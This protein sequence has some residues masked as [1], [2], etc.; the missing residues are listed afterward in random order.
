MSTRR[1]YGD[2]GK[3]LR[4]EIIN[5]MNTRGARYHKQA[6]RHELVESLKALGVSLATALI[7]AAWYLLNN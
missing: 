3:L 7:L 1:Y 5:E 4:Y 6:K 2:N